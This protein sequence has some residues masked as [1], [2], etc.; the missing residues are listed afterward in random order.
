MRFPK[1]HGVIRR[2]LLVNFRV[3]PGVIQQLLPSPFRPKLQDG[4]AIAGVCLIRLEDIRPP[5]VP[6]IKEW[7]P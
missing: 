1:V 4:H 2:R 7:C 6:Q 5:G 3:D